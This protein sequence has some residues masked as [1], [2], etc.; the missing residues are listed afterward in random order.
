MKKLVTLVLLLVSFS[1]HSAE[2]LLV[3]P[4]P[5]SGFFANTSPTHATLW[6]QPDTSAVVAML[7]GGDGSFNMKFAW[8][9]HRMTGIGST[10]ALIGDKTVTSGKL[11]GAFI[12]SPYSLGME[13]YPGARFSESHIKRVIGILQ[14][15]KEKTNKPIWLYGHSNG[16]IS[17]FEVYKYLKKTNNDLVAGIIVSGA[18]DV[19]KPPSNI[20]IPVLFIHH[21]D[22][23]CKDTQEHQ[24]MR[25][26]EKIKSTST[27]KTEFVRIS[28][29]VPPRGNAC[30]GG[31][32]MFDNLY[33]Q[34]STIIDRFVNQ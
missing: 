13:Y 14:L 20:D 8:R 2:E 30:L 25:H 1:A 29:Y 21:T 23:A 10:V 17:A 27:S 22:D 12:D 34:V 5:E 7:P 31:P 26:Y 16:S 33:P 32:H 11:S 24:A 6:D 18:R 19:I 15:I 4:S 28:D 3:A 9:A